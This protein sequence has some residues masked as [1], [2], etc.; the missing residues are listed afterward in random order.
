M[1]SPFETILLLCTTNSVASEKLAHK[2]EKATR[3]HISARCPY[4]VFSLLL[5]FLESQLLDLQ[6][7]NGFL[8]LG[9]LKKKIKK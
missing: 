6:F 5:L 8:S 2:R 3:I 1:K 4:I 9:D 7:M